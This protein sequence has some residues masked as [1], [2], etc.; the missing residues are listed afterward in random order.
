MK[1]RI[2]TLNEYVNEQKTNEGITH[3]QVLSDEFGG[4]DDKEFLYKAWRMT[5]SELKDLLST[6][7][8]DLAWCKKNSKGTLG[9]F[10]KRD[11]LFLKH[12]ISFIEQIIK[13]KN[14]NGEDYIT[15]LYKDKTNEG[16]S[17]SFLQY[18]TYK[19]IGRENDWHALTN[20]L[21]RSGHKKLISDIS[22]G[23]MIVSFEE[24]T[25]ITFI[26]INLRKNLIKTE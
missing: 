1:R 4:Y 19:F 5:L 26:P 13:T 10:N 9:Q 24:D 11:G 18:D 15:D 6:A 22:Y 23:D 3:I 16:Q 17:L 14:Q 21:N 7:V 20:I 2:P 12:R 8:K 25:D